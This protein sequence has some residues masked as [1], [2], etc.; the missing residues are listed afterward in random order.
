MK[1][2]KGIYSLHPNGIGIKTNNR[3]MSI[4]K[5]KGDVFVSSRVITDESVVLA[6]KGVEPL[7]CEA[8]INERGVVVVNMNLSRQT[9]ANLMVALQQYFLNED[10][11]ED[12]NEESR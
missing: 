1:L 2:D 3:R 9:A 11:I 12:I 4:V 6:K 10:K 8:K 7:V 5:H